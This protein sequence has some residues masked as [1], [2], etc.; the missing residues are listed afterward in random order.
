MTAAA[1]TTFDWSVTDP[2]YGK[3]VH[4]I[5]LSSIHRSLHQ[6]C[7]C[8]FS[9][10]GIFCRCRNSQRGWKCCRCGRSC[11]CSTQRHRTLQYRIGETP[12]VS[13]YD[14]EKRTVRAL[15]GSGRALTPLTLDVLR[16]KGVDGVEIPGNSIHSVTVP[17]CRSCRIDTVEKLGSGKLTMQG[18]S[19]SCHRLAEQG[20]PFMKAR[21]ICG[22]V[23]RI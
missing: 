9:T 16:S 1:R 3:P 18:H 15:N 5:C 10:L 19:R 2:H 6:G 4:A 14:A 20:Y 17:V 22:A 23:A 11:G 7:R 13:F 8:L 21:I 12:F